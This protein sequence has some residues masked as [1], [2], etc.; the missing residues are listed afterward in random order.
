ME[1]I[2]YSDIPTRPESG[3][4]D[5]SRSSRFTD[6]PEPTTTDSAPRSGGVGYYF[7]ET[8]TKDLTPSPPRSSS[9]ATDPSPRSRGARRENT[10]Q[11]SSDPS[12]TTNVLPSLT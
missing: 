8:Y 4:T 6:F 5:R 7:V 11:R 1:L 3:L 12:E 9:G 2:P 10:E